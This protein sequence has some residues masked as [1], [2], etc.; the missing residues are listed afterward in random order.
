MGW[1]RLRRGD[2][3]DQILT[4]WIEREGCFTHADIERHCRIARAIMPSALTPTHHTCHL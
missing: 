1:D 2:V 3:G 4:H